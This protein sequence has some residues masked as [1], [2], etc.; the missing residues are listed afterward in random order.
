MEEGNC[1]I[2]TT[3][4]NRPIRYQKSICK[5]CSNLEIKDENGFTVNFQ[6][7][8]WSGGFESLHVGEGNQIIKK[9]EHV[10]YINGV[11]C[12]ADEARF[13]GIVIQVMESAN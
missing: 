11:K 2:C 8:D 9:A 5:S 10:C 3:L 6:N 4:F 7:I 12:W 13:G 1:P